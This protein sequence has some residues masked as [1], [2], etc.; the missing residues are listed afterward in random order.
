MKV[1]AECVETE[2]Q[3]DFLRSHGCDE[4][5]GYH[6]GRPVSAAIFAEKFRSFYVPLP[7]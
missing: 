7:V 2:D 5:Q 4:V 1:I 3:V 6:F